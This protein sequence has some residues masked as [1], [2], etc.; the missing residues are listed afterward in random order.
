MDIFSYKTIVLNSFGDLRSVMLVYS[1]GRLGHSGSLPTERAGER[2]FPFPGAKV[3][4]YFHT[5][6]YFSII[7]DY[8]S[9]ATFTG[10]EGLL[11]RSVLI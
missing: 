7:R 5:S 2:L 6:K 9:L 11:S 3:L 4:T 1:K 8:K 10:D